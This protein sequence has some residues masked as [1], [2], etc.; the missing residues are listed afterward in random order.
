MPMLSVIVVT[1]VCYSWTKPTTS[2]AILSLLL[3]K[4]KSLAKRQRQ[5]A[6]ET[7]AD[8]A[9]KKMRLE[10][11]QRGHVVCYQCMLVA[12]SPGA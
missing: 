5:E 1:V 6:E 2:Q 7:K 3:Q 8:K 4:S 9:A 12:L 10:M 11:K